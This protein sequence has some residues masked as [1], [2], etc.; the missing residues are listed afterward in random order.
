MKDIIDRITKMKMKYFIPICMTIGLV[1]G[2]AIGMYNEINHDEVIINE[3]SFISCTDADLMSRYPDPRQ[4]KNAI[5]NSEEFC[6]VSPQIQQ[7][8]DGIT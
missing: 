5:E 1:G 3:Q 4:L 8:L 2:L 6:E 7:V